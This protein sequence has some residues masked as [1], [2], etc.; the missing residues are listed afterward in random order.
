MQTQY[1]SEKKYKSVKALARAALKAEGRYPLPKPTIKEIKP[2]TIEE[3][4]S[5]E[6]EIEEEEHY[7]VEFGFPLEKLTDDEKQKIV[8]IVDREVKMIGK[9]SGGNLVSFDMDITIERNTPI[10]LNINYNFE[11]KTLEQ[12]QH[13]FSLMRSCYYVKWI[14][15]CV[16]KE[17]V[18]VVY[19]RFNPPDVIKFNDMDREIL[20]QVVYHLRK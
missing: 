7:M 15:R 6:K 14:H 2:E 5:Q 9:S 3:K 1:N 4:Q 20:K 10:V 13:L 18:C 11:Y 16:K 17:I 19:D 12:I 8:D